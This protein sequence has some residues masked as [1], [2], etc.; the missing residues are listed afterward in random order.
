MER[1]TS[2]TIDIS[3]WTDFGYYDLC[4]Y[5]Y[6]QESEENPRINRWIGVS[7]RVIS[8]L[9]FWILTEKGKVI[10]RKTDP[11]VTKDEAATDYFQRSIGHYHKFLA[12]D[13]G[14]GDHYASDLDGLGGFTNDDV[15]KPSKTYEEAYN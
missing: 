11:H 15:P 10:S 14:I 3:E 12:E 9:C 2:D 7:H 4:Q 13:S 1:I 8:M 5:W 6:K